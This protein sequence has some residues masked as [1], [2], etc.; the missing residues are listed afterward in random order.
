MRVWKLAAGLVAASV[1]GCDPI[2]GVQ[3]NIDLKTP[4]DLGC[5]DQTIRKTSGVGEVSHQVDQTEGTQ[6]L[7]Y[8]GKVITVMEAWQY[9]GD[10]GGTVQIS[11]DGKKIVF[12]NGRLKIGN[13][14]PKADLDAYVPLMNRVN[15]AL[16]REC[17]LPLHEAGKITRN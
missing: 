10:K 4:L 12:F 16:E 14:F 13:P 8:R 2:R 15:A 9:G 1:G 5:V 3:T 17:G 11:N 6:I 7:P